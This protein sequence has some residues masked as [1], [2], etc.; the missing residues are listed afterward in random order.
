MLRT[1]AVV[2]Q[3][4]NNNRPQTVGAVGEKSPKARLRGLSPPVD[5]LVDQEGPSSDHRRRRPGSNQF[6]ADSAE[7]CLQLLETGWVLVT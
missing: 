1:A 4:R 2:T 7:P 6:S 3:R 5:R